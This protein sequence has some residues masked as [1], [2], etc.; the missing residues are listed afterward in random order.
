VFAVGE[1]VNGWT[2]AIPFPPSVQTGC[3]LQLLSSIP[4]GVRVTFSV[5]QPNTD[6]VVVASIGGGGAVNNGYVT[7]KTTSF[8]D[9]QFVDVADNAGG[10]LYFHVAR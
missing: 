1:V 5:L 10:G 4:L 9:I 2:G 6:Y 3:T 8:V 7:T